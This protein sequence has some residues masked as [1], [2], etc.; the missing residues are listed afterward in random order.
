MALKSKLA[1]FNCKAYKVR[2]SDVSWLQQNPMYIHMCML[3]Y[4]VLEYVLCNFIW[5]VTT[6][7]QTYRSCSVGEPYTASQHGNDVVMN[8][9]YVN[10]LAIN[11]CLNGFAIVIGMPQYISIKPIHGIQH[12]AIV[13]QHDAVRFR[14]TTPQRYI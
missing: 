12:V 7:A 6:Q 5:T 13:I 14:Y 4:V 1:F 8:N 10:I 9:N 11:E 2:P 3:T